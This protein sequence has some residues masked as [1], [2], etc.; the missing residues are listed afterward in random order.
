MEVPLLERLF[1]EFPV[2]GYPVVAPG[3][4]LEELADGWTEEVAFDSSFAQTYRRG[5]SNKM[6]RL[7]F[8]L[9]SST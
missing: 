2:T 8:L 4:S 3:T 1:G 9:K 7:D 5:D 6:I